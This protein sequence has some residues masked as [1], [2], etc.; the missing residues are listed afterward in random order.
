MLTAIGAYLD[1][2]CYNTEHLW[3]QRTQSS[4][5][6]QQECVQRPVFGFI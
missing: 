5:F 4:L 2:S 1:F 3:Y 6:S